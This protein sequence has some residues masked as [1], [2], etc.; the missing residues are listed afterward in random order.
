MF[1]FFTNLVN[2]EDINIQTKQIN[3]SI[4]HVEF[5]P[6]S[7]DSSE[8]HM[9]KKTPACSYCNGTTHNIIKCEQVNTQLEQIKTYCSETSHQ[10]NVIGT[11]TWL[12]TFDNRVLARYIIIHNINSYMWNNCVVYYANN[13]EKI[14]G[15]D[16]NIQLIIGYEC[17]L[18]AHPEIRIKKDQIKKHKDSNENNKK[19]YDR[20]E[21]SHS[22]FGTNLI[23]AS[24]ILGTGI[25]NSLLIE[26]IN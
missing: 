3:S 12:K 16:K 19:S 26:K 11:T 22:S 8:V 10:T 5:K 25:T 6:K 20:F 23:G 2:Y 4:N 15:K 17:V 13:I 9:H 18:P 1:K 7:Q 14:S 21:N 24:L